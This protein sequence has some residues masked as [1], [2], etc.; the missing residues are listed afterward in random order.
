MGETENVATNR[1]DENRKEEE[2]GQYYHIFRS[3]VEAKG[4]LH[5][6]DP[7]ECKILYITLKY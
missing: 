5:G 6:S 3:D 2:G 4:S 1:T 7:Q